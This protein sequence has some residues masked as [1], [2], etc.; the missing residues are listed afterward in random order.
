MELTVN[1]GLRSFK[2][3]PVEIVGDQALA[4]AALSLQ[5][6]LYDCGLTCVAMF[7]IRSKIRHI[8]LE[9]EATRGPP[10]NYAAL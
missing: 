6:T 7:Q 3:Q 5:R 1:E 4:Y 10:V 2:T 8:R 9:R